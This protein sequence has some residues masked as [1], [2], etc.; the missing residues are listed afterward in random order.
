MR[1]P[2]LV[3][4]VIAVA[5]VSL[6]PGAADAKECYRYGGPRINYLQAWHTTCKAA[7]RVARAATRKGNDGIDEPRVYGYACKLIYDGS[8]VQCTK[9][10]RRVRWFFTEGE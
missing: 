6:T 5:A 8:G 3:I 4:A 1:I 7:G 2:A 9:G 10:I